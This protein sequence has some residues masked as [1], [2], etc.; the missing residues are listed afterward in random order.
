LSELSAWLILP[1]GYPAWHTIVSHTLAIVPIVVLEA[2]GVLSSTFAFDGR[3]LVLTAPVIDLTPT[4]AA[5][6]L[7]I[8]FATQFANMAFIM[9]SSRKGQDALQ[10]REHS[11][12]WH[13]EQ[14]LPRRQTA[15]NR[16]PR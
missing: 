13:L 7:A 5:L 6:M 2:V 1:T 12:T 10:E 11:H 16:R 15:G 8:T 3:S 14:L 9:I 4:P